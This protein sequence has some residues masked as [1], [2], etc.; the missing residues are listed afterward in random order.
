ME[1][2][3]KIVAIFEHPNT[4]LFHKALVVAAG[5]FLLWLVLLTIVHGLGRK[6]TFYNSSATVVRSSRLLVTNFCLY[7]VFSYL[8]DLYKLHHLV[9]Y[10]HCA[11]VVL[12]ALP[13]KNLTG[14]LFQHLR[15][16]GAGRQITPVQDVALE[17]AIKL[18]DVIML[19]I[20]FLLAPCA[21]HQ[22]HAVHGQCRYCHRY[23]RQR[24]PLQYDC[25]DSAHY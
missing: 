1:T 14:A 21:G 23:C 9:I 17:L 11:L 12:L 7:V 20:F 6:S 15:K 10:L 25:R 5:I 19:A 24:Y 22:H 8:L 3:H 4:P 16:K 13:V 2:Y 18:N